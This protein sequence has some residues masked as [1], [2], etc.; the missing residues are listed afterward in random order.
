MFRRIIIQKIKSIIC[1]FN[2]YKPPVQK[3]LFN[4]FFSFKQW[5]LLMYFR[6]NIL[7]YL[8]VHC[9]KNYLAV[10]SMFGLAQQICSNKLRHTGIIGINRYFAWPSEHI[11]CNTINIYQLLCAGY[12]LISGPENFIYFLNSLRS[13]SHRR[14]GLCATA[15]INIFDSQNIGSK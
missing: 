12:I 11:Y 1:I 13:V 10:A 9:N 14:Y 2:D 8:F 15:F 3:A 6:N 7:N 4:C 5:Q